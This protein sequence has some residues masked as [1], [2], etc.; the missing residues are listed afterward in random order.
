[1]QTFFRC[2]RTAGAA[3]ATKVEGIGGLSEPRR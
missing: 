3:N 1:M 2:S